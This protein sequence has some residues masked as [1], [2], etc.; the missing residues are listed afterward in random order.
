MSELQTLFAFGKDSVPHTTAARADIPGNVADK[1]ALLA[2]LARQLGF[3]NYFGNNWDAFEECIRDLSWLPHGPVLVVHADVPLVG[4]PASAMTYVAIL[5]DAANK[6]ARSEGRPL[7]VAFPPQHRDR[8][9]WL[10]RA[11]EARSNRRAD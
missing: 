7:L 5:N 10:L 6:M 8:V 1:A 4:D 2:T 11:D 3:P 9:M